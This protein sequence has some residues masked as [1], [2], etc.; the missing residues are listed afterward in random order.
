MP[1][2]KFHAPPHAPESRPAPNKT[3]VYITVK[4]QS[5]VEIHILTFVNGY[6]L[7]IA[8][9]PIGSVC[10]YSLWRNFF[11]TIFMHFFDHFHAFFSRPFSCIFFRPFSCDYILIYRS[12]MLNFLIIT[13]SLWGLTVAL[14]FEPSVAGRGAPKLGWVARLVVW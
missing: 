5:T 6:A 3:A 9:C 2:W 7:S 1:R 12:K 14:I 10:K 8:Y 4:Y 13:Y 11:P